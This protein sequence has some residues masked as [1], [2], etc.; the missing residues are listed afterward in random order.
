L[1]DAKRNGEPEQHQQKQS[2][3]RDRRGQA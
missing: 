3:D 1:P 2:H